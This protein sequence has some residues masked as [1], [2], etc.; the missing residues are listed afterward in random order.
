MSCEQTG[1]RNDPPQEFVLN[2]EVEQALQPEIIEEPLERA[3]L[4]EQPIHK[5]KKGRPKGCT[6]ASAKRREEEEDDWSEHVQR[7]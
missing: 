5:N 3:V 6:K 2:I 1:G 7:R 4:V